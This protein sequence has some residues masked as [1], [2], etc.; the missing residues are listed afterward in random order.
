MKLLTQKAL[1]FLQESGAKK[2]TLKGK[3]EREQA[4][5]ISSTS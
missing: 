5:S 4:S 1:F 3:V 2:K